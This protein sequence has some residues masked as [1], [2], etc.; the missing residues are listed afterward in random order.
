MHIIS[1][2]FYEKIAVLITNTTFIVAKQNT[3]PIIIDFGIQSLVPHTPF[4]YHLFEEGDQNYRFLIDKIGKLRFIGSTFFFF[5]LP[6]D[7]IWQDRKVMTEFF[8]FNHSA[9]SKPPASLF[10]TQSLLLSADMYKNYISFSRT[11]R[12]FALHYIKSGKI[13]QVK[14]FSE[15]SNST[16]EN[17]YIVEQFRE[18][19]GTHLPI[20]INGLSEG[21][22]KYQGIGEI[23]FAKTMIANC[24][25]WCNSHNIS[26][27]G[28]IIQE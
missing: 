11:P 23:I 8:Y 15:G 5:A 21:M 3:E 22:E 6:D 19:C 14:F 4:Y 9:R 28:H 18:S 27:W 13:A 26:L 1:N 17:M 24:R 16:T 20:Y 10:T 7:D 2:L 12:C 25:N